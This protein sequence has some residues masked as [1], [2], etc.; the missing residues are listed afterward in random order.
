MRLETAK[1]GIFDMVSTL[2]HSKIAA[3]SKEA[4]EVMVSVW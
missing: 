2:V 1:M 4:K 3:I